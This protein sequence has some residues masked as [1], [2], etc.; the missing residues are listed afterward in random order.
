MSGSDSAKD[1]QGSSTQEL[2]KRIAELEKENSKLKEQAELF[3]LVMD[4]APIGITIH[5]D[6]IVKRTNPENLRLG[7][8]K[9]MEEAIGLNVLDF[10]AE[11]SLDL[12]KERTKSTYDGKKPVSR[13]LE[14]FITAS[15]E[16]KD[17]VVTTTPCKF[18]GKP[19]SLVMF[20]DVTSA[21][22]AERALHRQEVQFKALFE[23]VL[24]GQANL[25]TEGQFLVVNSAM[26]RLTGYSKDE[27]LHMGTKELTHPDDI[28][29]T[30]DEMHRLITRESDWFRMEKRILKKDGS[31]AW[32][33]LSVRTLVDDEGKVESLLGCM[34]DI[35]ERVKAE[36]KLERSEKLFRAIVE[37]SGDGISLADEKGQYLLVNSA[38]TDLL[39]YN[40]D[41][42]LAKSVF[43]ML[44]SGGESG[45]YSKAINGESWVFNG[46]LL[47]KDGSKFWAEV[48]AFPIEIDN[49]R[50][51]LGMVR[52]ITRRREEEKERIALEA[53]IQKTQKLESLGVLA[54]GI[55]HDFNN[56]LVGVLGNADLALHDLAPEAP[57]RSSVKDIVTAAE[58]ATEL[59]RQMLAYAGKG[60]FLVEVL[61]LNAVVEEMTHLLDVSISKKAILRFDL[62][63]EIPS[64]EADATQIRQ[65]VMNLITN[66]SDAIG[67]RS[68][69]ISIRT[70]AMECDKA[71]LEETYLDDDLKEGQYVY[72]EVSDTGQGMDEE[73]RQKVFD[74]FFSTKFTGRGLGLAAVLG[75][76]RSHKGAIKI[77]SEPGKG[78]TFKVLLP[79]VQLHPEVRKISKED[80]KVARLC[81]T[82]MLV[83]DEETVRSVGKR[84]IEHLGCQVVTCEEGKEAIEKFQEDP[85][86]FH[87]VILDLTMPHMDGDACYRELRRIRPD[88]KVILASGYN[89]AE[90]VA[91]F[92]GKG[93]AG[94]MQKPFR[95]DTLADKIREALEDTQ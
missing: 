89:Q 92:A 67:D 29:D 52:D 69:V 31:I 10:V 23:N 56:L 40:K 8:F 21:L 24:I 64:I 19:A 65:V 9:S 78:T 66:A 90:L 5:Q 87:L 95:L 43:D 72:L 30:F 26:S 74:P 71:Y 6:Y 28:Q 16:A 41:E 11:S 45:L 83:D 27:L 70:G 39:G 51:V 18:E 35:S 25:T 7:G 82:V 85:D 37:Q 13:V 73:I 57:A 44:P 46:E 84:M 88:V 93:I 63:E 75:I 34:V 54:G 47:R 17:V 68:G 50:Q 42:F 61:D 53:Q 33:D 79:A 91:R 15:G 22:D 1:G 48:S 38:M 60:K 81:G 86:R 94:F 20:S 58:R 62:N 14:S 49:K 4:H 59:V 32:V 3:D 77:Y 80:R 55:A 76:V 36:K 2:Q 12:A